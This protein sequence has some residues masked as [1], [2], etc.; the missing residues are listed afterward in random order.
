MKENYIVIQNEDGNWLI[1]DEVAQKI[2][3]GEDFTF[4]ARLDD[5]QLGDTSTYLRCWSKDEKI[6]LKH[7][8]K[9]K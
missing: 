6:I 2:K 7:V 5:G 8:K 3:D 4:N 1:N 9:E